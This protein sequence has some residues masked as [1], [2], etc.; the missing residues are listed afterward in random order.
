MNT[1]FLDHLYSFR[2]EIVFFWNNPGVLKTELLSNHQLLL[3]VIAAVVV[4]LLLLYVLFKPAKPKVPKSTTATTISQHKKTPATP[5][6]FSNALI[7]QQKKEP[8]IRPAT[9]TKKAPPPIHEL[10]EDEEHAL[11]EAMALAG[12]QALA[13]VSGEPHQ[14]EIFQNTHASDAAKKIFGR[15]KQELKSQAQ[16][17]EEVSAIEFIMIYFMAPR[18]QAFVNA[19]L[20]T[21]FSK[22]GLVLNDQN[23]FEYVEHA[24]TLFFV[25]SAIKPGPFDV[26][27]PN[28]AVPGILFVLD[29]KACSNPQ[30]A[31]N[32]MLGLLDQTSMV[33]KGDILD[34][35]RKRL[36]QGSIHQYLARIKA[37]I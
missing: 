14:A 37:S 5:K 7:E 12:K 30:A 35:S 20:F 28:A 24:E 16:E 25:T 6:T 3:E 18:S 13:E 8:S 26:Q 19:E 1:A 31:F 22:L 29:L 15:S 27:N 21:M 34:E 17:T 10:S 32:K 36:T 4:L 11:K 33:L 2:D 23:V 9:I